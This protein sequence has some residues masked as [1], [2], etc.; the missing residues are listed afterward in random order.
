MRRP[1][2]CAAA[3]VAAGLIPARRGIAML[4]PCRWAP[5]RPPLEEVERPYPRLPRSREIRRRWITGGGV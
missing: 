4:G 3:R 1:P 2:R 5:W